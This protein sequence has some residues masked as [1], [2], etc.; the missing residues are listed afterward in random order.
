MI[1]D[2]RSLYDH[3]H[4]TGSM[5]SERSVMI[6]L[7]S[8]KDMVEAGIIQLR[9]CPT[10][11][12]LSDHLTKTMKCDLLKQF[13]TTGRVQLTQTSEQQQHEQHKASLRQAQRQRRKTKMKAVVTAASKVLYMF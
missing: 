2:A 8:A 11:H 5:P 12:Q 3:L 4:A 13:M 6:D 10:Q 9:W 7:L 1:T